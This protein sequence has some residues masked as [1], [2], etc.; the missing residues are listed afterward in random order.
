[1][2]SSN[3]TH[4]VGQKTANA[5]GLYDMH[6]NVWEWCADWYDSG[7]Y[8]KSSADDPTGPKT[9]SYRVDRGGSWYYGGRYCQSAS[10]DFRVPSRLRI[11][12]LGLRVAR[13]PA[14]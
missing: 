6:G 11:N 12:D 7:Y 3:K 10:R 9:G 2:N 1:M 8:G 14:D 13:V 5:W 4:P